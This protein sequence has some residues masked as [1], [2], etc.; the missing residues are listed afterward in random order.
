MNLIILDTDF[1]AVAILDVYE[2]FIWTDRFFECGD[3]ELYTLVTDELLE[4]LQIDYYIVNNESEHAM[5]IEDIEISADAED[6]NHL[7][8][9]GRS[10]ESILDRRI[11]W[12][13]KTLS[14]KL[15]TAIKT[16]ITEA[17][18]SP[19]NS[20]RQ[21]SNF[22]FETTDDETI[23]ALTVDCQ[24]TGDNLYDAIVSLCQSNGIGFKVI[25]NDDNEFVFKLYSGSDRSYEQTDNPY[26]VFSSNYE[27]INNSNYLESKSSYK[28]V[29]LIGGEGEGTERVYAST[30]SAT[31][32]DR[33]EMF[34]DARDVSSED[35]DG[36][37]LSD[38]EY[39]ALL[40]ERGT[41]DLAEN[42][43]VSSFEGSA[44][45][46]LMYTLNEDY[47]IGDIV[48]IM[49]DY[50]HEDRVRVVEIVI[51]E[52][53]EGYTVYPTFVSVSEESDE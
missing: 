24:F 30:G 53:E 41:E 47:Y 15:Q 48:Q 20:D 13:L 49:D 2:S 28:N 4:N 17:I 10:L 38:S 12:G 44:D 31:G 16:L 34:T 46:T 51:S 50:G 11:I 27:N 32:M 42:T 7:T 5:I 22:T 37:T 43:E 23:T 1:N 29:A 36:N 26:V 25:L 6:G 40:V 39:E 3:F 45:T 8:V 35:E 52:S 19:S 18:I 33:R 21:I 9:T 14:G